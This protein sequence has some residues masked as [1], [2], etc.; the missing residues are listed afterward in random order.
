MAPRSKTVNRQFPP[1]YRRGEI[2]S[3]VILNIHD[4]KKAFEGQCQWVK[5]NK[6]WL[7]RRW[8]S[9]EWDKKVW[10]T[11]RAFH[12]LVDVPP[13]PWSIP[14]R[15]CHHAVSSCH[16]MGPC[17]WTPKVQ[18]TMDSSVQAYRRHTWHVTAWYR[19]GW[20][21]RDQ[22]LQTS[23]ACQ[24]HTHTLQ[25][26]T[27][28]CLLG[29]HLSFMDLVPVQ[30]T[31]QSTQRPWCRNIHRYTPWEWLHSLWQEDEVSRVNPLLFYCSFDF[32]DCTCGANTSS[33]FPIFFQ[34]NCVDKIR[35]SDN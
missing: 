15:G 7:H 2:V 16:H 12:M 26:G 4:N 35:Q 10:C 24:C 22:L 1:H 17:P 3:R 33:S 19:Q 20:P 31:L 27:L 32:C 25:P 8:T 18:C 11:N 6:T 29:R 9:T 13:L 34:K 14:C 5:W 30:A 23:R 28:W 21:P